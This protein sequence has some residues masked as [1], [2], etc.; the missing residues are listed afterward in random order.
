MTITPTIK[1][2]LLATA[3]VATTAASLPSIDLQ[4]ALALLGAFMTGVAA[5][6]VT[7]KVTAP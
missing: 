5:F 6:N 3:G 7:G 1:R 4:V 2:V